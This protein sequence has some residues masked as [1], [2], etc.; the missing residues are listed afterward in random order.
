MKGTIFSVFP[1]EKLSR[2][3]TSYPSPRKASH[4]FEPINPAPPVI[5]IFCTIFDSFICMNMVRFLLF[6][7]LKKFYFEV[8]AEDVC[9]GRIF[10]EK[11]KGEVY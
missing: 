10:K 7:C 3:I 2:Q 9:K 11:D 6:K 4:K 8:L 5:S 1:V